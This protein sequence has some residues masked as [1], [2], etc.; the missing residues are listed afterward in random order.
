MIPVRMHQDERTACMGKHKH[1][2]KSSTHSR[3]WFRS[4]DSGLWTKHVTSA[5]LAE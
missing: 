2:A 3:E 4:A 1:Y 5:P